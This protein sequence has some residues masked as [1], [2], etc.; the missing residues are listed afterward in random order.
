MGD[1]LIDDAPAL[2]G[3]GVVGAGQEEDLAGPLVPDLPG[4]ERGA[5]A[6]VEAADIGVSLLEARVL[7]RGQRQVAHDVEA[8]TAAGG[9]ARDSGDDGLGH[10]ADEALNLQD[11]EPAGPCGVEAGLSGGDVGLVAVGAILGLAGGRWG[12]WRGLPLVAVAVPAADALVAAGGEGPAAVARGGAVAG[13]DDGADV[14]AHA[15]VV[16]DPVELIDGAGAEGVTD[17]GP[18]EGHS[19]HGQI[20]EPAAVL[21]PDAAPVVGDVR[22]GLRLLLGGL[23]AGL[24]VGKAGHLPPAVGGEDL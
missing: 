19:D 5:V 11:V 17:L 8:V 1:R 23:R 13:E 20:P 6:G 10:G 2:G 3:D 21:S 15:R 18:V 24:G 22:Q 14:A 16:Q 9:P 12:L 4:Q 7:D